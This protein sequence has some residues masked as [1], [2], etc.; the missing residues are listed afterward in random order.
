MFVHTNPLAGLFVSFYN[1]GMVLFEK[2]APLNP[3]NPY[4]DYKSSPLSALSGCPISW[5]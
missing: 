2:G 4:R 3:G 1:A 5:A